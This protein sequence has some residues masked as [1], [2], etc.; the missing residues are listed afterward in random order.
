LPFS[1]RVEPRSSS[2]N[3]G[4]GDP[5]HALGVD[6]DTLTSRPICFSFFRTHSKRF[7]RNIAASKADRHGIGTPQGTELSILSM[8]AGIVNQAEEWQKYNFGVRLELPLKRV[9]ESS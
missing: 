1:N 5:R 8:A 2:R 4:V 3:G 7:R 6:R 9:C